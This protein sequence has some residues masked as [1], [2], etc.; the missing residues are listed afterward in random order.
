M[1]Q[2]KQFWQFPGSQ[3]DTY[4][5]SISVTDTNAYADSIIRGPKQFYLWH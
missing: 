1:W 2:R 4:P 5:N 3:P